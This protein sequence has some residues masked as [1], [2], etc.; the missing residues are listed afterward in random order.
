GRAQTLSVLSAPTVTIFAPSALTPTPRTAPSWAGSIL[1][2]LP[3]AAFH[4]PAVLSSLAERTR[5]PLGLKT[6][7]RTGLACDA[8]QTRAGGQ[9]PDLDRLVGPAGRDPGAVLAQRQAAHR[10]A[11]VHL[12]HRLGIGDVPDL[13]RLVGA[14]RDQLVALGVVEQG[15]HRPGVPRDRLELL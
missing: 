7:W 10:R 1:T 6:A 12:Q 11:V 4:T 9:R 13:H 5:S 3:S 14:G 2:G 8:S 15:G